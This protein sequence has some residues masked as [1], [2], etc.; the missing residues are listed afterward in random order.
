MRL[1]IR[2]PEDPRAAVARAARRAELELL[3]ARVTSAPRSR[4]AHAAAQPITPAPTIATRVTGLAAT[5]PRVDEARRCAVER[6]LHG[7]PAATGPLPL[8]DR[9]GDDVPGHEA[10]VELGM[11]EEPVPV[12]APT[13]ELVCVTTTG[14]GSS[15]SRAPSHRELRRVPVVHQREPPIIAAPT[16]AATRSC[17]S[18]ARRRAARARAVRPVDAA[19]FANTKSPSVEDPHR[20][21]VQHRRAEARRRRAGTRRARARRRRR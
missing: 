11:V 9:A 8:D 10:R 2:E 13:V 4:S 12:D 3:V 19:G 20:R 21:R 17:A 16:T 14:P 15:R 1:R 7:A 18:I 5:T 6:E